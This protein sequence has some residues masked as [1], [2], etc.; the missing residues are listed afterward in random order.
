MGKTAAIYKLE[1][2]PEI[3]INHEKALAEEGWYHRF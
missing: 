3:E 1:R 2:E